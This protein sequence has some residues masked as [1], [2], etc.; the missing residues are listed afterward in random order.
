MI[1]APAAT[2]KASELSSWDA[3]AIW[4]HAPTA[5][6]LTHACEKANS[7]AASLLPLGG[8][9]TAAASAGSSLVSA[10]DTAA[11]LLQRGSSKAL[12]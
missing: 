9:A 12:G 1:R 5:W 3:A 6:K 8:G 11:S 2:R 10:W 7:V 4:A